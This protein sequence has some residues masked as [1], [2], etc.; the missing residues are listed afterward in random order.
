MEKYFIYYILDPAGLNF[1]WKLYFSLCINNIMQLCI[2]L[3][4]IMKG[5]LPITV[6]SHGKLSIKA[7]LTQCD[8]VL[9]TTVILS[10]LPRLLHSSHELLF[11]RACAS[12]AAQFTQNTYLCHVRVPLIELLQVNSLITMGHRWETLAADGWNG[13]GRDVLQTVIRHNH[14]GWKSN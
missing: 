1:R 12:C 9:C 3:F 2:L 10:F 6:I 5:I 4:F 7:C 13:P 8:R 14:H 11:I